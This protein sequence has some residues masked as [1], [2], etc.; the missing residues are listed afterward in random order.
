MKYRRNWAFEQMSTV[1]YLDGTETQNLLQTNNKGQ[2]S[3]IEIDGTPYTPDQFGMLGISSVHFM[4]PAQLQ[5]DVPYDVM[6]KV[7][8]E[9]GETISEGDTMRKVDIRSEIADKLHKAGINIHEL[10]AALPDR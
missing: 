2:I 6:G 4:V 7:Y 5:V 1:F 8:L 10:L 3:F 9:L